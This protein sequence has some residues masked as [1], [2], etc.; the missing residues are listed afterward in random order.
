[1]RSANSSCEASRRAA[2]LRRL[3]AHNFIGGAPKT[4]APTLNAA[5]RAA[6][7][8]DAQTERLVCLHS[9]VLPCFIRPSQD[10]STE[11]FVLVDIPVSRYRS[12]NKGKL[13]VRGTHATFT[14]CVY[15]STAAVSA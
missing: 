15:C 6:P 4:L 1:M 11:D 2:G 12:Y 7:P 14:V 10:L 3:S 5:E 8:A 9:M 13:I